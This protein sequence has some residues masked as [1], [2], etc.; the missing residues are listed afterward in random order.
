MLRVLVAALLTVL[1]AGCA[2]VH[3]VTLSYYLVS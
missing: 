3:D 1:L 2:K